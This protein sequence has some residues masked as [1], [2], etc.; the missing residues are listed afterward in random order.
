MQR[1]VE[2][3]ECLM[4]AVREECRNGSGTK[5][6][7]LRALSRGF[8]RMG[9]WRLVER[10]CRGLHVLVVQELADVILWVAS[11]EPFEHCCMESEVWQ[12]EVC[13][14]KV[15]QLARAQ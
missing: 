8:W 6:G 15:R 13:K 12:C 11:I 2:G 14:C 9:R 10:W 3:W 1:G 7:I 5:D 4:M